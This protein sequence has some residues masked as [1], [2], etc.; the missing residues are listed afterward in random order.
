MPS[1]VSPGHGSCAPF[2]LGRQRLSSPQRLRPLPLIDDVLQG[3]VGLVVEE[4][5]IVEGGAGAVAGVSYGGGDRAALDG[6]ALADL[7][8]VVVAIE[9]LEAEAVG[10]D[11]GVAVAR[12][13]AGEGHHPIGRG[14]DGGAGGGGEIDAGGRLGLAGGGG[15]PGAEAGG[16]VA[17]GGPQ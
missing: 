17:L 15:R 10:E 7:V 16:D 11:Q 6:L 14:A 12:E 4:V 13:G 2:R 9:G 1:S 3:V 5:F 8:P